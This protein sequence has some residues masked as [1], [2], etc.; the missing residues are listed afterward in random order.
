MQTVTGYITNVVNP[1][2]SGIATVHVRTN[3]YPTRLAI[4]SDDERMGRLG[5]TL[6]DVGDIHTFYTEAGYGV[7]QLAN[8]F[9]GF[10]REGQ[11]TLAAFTI[12]D[13]GMLAD[14]EVLEGE[15]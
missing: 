4:P 2:F 11:H 9:D 12:D 5:Y 10:S 13:M 7:R 1:N 8:L 14:V 6:Y 3:K 15:A